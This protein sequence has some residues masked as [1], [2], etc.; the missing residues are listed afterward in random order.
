MENEN[1]FTPMYELKDAS[2]IESRLTSYPRE[3]VLVYPQKVMTTNP[4]WDDLIVTKMDD[5]D[6]KAEGLSFCFVR[7]ELSNLCL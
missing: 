2:Q 5:D 4:D 3:I 7:I 6:S 1:E